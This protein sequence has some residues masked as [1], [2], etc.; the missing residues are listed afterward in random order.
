M[1]RYLLAGASVLLT[2]VVVVVSMLGA[3]PR[4]VHMAALTAIKEGDFEM[5]LSHLKRS[6]HPDAEALMSQM[7]YVPN[8]IS[9]DTNGAISTENYVYT[10]AGRLYKNES[11]AADGTLKVCVYSYNALGNP[12]EC[13]ITVQQPLPEP[14]PETP[15]VPEE[16]VIADE[17][18][19]DYREEYFYD[20]LGRL[21][22]KRTTDST[23]LFYQYRY[24]YDLLGRVVSEVYV[25]GDA[26][27][28]RREYTYDGE[29][30]RL[31]EKYTDYAGTWENVTNTYA[32][33]I[34]RTEVTEN[35]AGVTTTLYDE[36]GVFLSKE[37]VLK[38]GTV[39]KTLFTY[40]EAG[41][42]L[43]EQYPD[44]SA[45]TYTYNDL[46]RCT[47][48][49]VIGAD[50]TTQQSNVHTYDEDGF[51]LTSVQTD[52]A[53]Q[54]TAEYTYNK[55][56]Q[57]VKEHHVAADGEWRTVE[58][59][60]DRYDNPEDVVETTALGTVATN[61]QWKVRYYPDGMPDNIRELIELYDVDIP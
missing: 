12:V 6:D 20:G 23:G 16:E 21:L 17:N 58:Y 28:T 34:L 44:G 53:G 43:R 29:T 10:Q 24:T 14:A 55:K 45:V 59:S 38:D 25:D 54:T 39:N 52:G 9:R 4:T 47:Q 37:E 41:H 11:T 1:K 51:M 3:T 19:T 60:Y 36:Q 15:P 48:R 56:H 8:K 13:Q 26:K 30:E 35:A 40:D 61:I 18:S 46:G 42:L 7:Y 2:I 5:A 22:C 32:G 57:L 31:T 49:L 33:E 27:W 50:G